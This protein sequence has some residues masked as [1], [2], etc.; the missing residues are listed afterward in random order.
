MEP[1]VYHN[2]SLNLGG[3]ALPLSFDQQKQTWLDS[4]RFA[5][6]ST[7]QEIPD[8]K[9]RI[10]W[11]AYP[12]ELAEGTAAAAA[13]YAHVASKLGISTDYD[14]ASAVPAGVLI[15]PV[16]LEDSVLYVMESDSADEAKIDLRD[17]LTGAHL[18]LRLPAQ[19]AALALIGKQT[20]SVV[21]KYGF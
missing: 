5:D 11:A 9:G 6:G 7:F 15:Y 10:F 8:G 14:L 19:H 18:A 3:K 2:A 17:K 21:A 1:L 20:K 12:V 4:L 13:L 16:V